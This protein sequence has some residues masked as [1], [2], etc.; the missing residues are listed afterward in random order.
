MSSVALLSNA[1]AKHLA[2]LYPDGQ[3]PGAFKPCMALELSIDGILD[4]KPQQLCPGSPPGTPS[5]PSLGQ[6]S[7]SPPKAICLTSTPALE[8][9]PNQSLPLHLPL[10]EHQSDVQVWLPSWVLK[11]LH[12]PQGAWVLVTRSVRPKRQSNHPNM[13]APGLRT[14]SVVAQVRE[15]SMEPM[16]APG[17]TR[18]QLSCAGADGSRHGHACNVSNAQGLGIPKAMQPTVALHAQR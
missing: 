14:R 5:T 6:S 11:Q 8:A 16:V 13:A 15:L 3:V 12:L 17:S 10:A 2:S 7:A 1:L 18:G 4:S 9:L